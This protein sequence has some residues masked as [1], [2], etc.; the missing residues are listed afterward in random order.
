[1]VDPFFGGSWRLARVAL[2]LGRNVIG[3][4]MKEEYLEMAKD[5]AIYGE[6][7]LS[8]EKARRKHGATQELLF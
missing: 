6:K 4:D 2:S 3:I 8:K 5:V 1:M 7:G